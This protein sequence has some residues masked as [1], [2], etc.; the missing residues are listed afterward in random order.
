MK[1]P[2]SHKKHSLPV[3]TTGEHCPLNGWWAPTDQATGTTFITEGSIMPAKAGKCVTW[4][5]I[6]G[7]SDPG[8]VKK[9]VA[10]GAPFDSY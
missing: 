6:A 1:K 3:S 10:S 9:A 8:Q 2:I 7:Q 4:T 5:L